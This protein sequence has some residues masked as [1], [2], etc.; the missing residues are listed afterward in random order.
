MADAQSISAA[1]AFVT[2]SGVRRFAELLDQREGISVEL[3]ARAAGVTSPDALLRLRDELGVDV[4]VVIG[5]HAA[6]FHP[7]LWLVRSRD[8]LSVMAGSGNL[9][10]GGLCENDEQ[11][12]LSRLQLDSD[13]AA[14]HEE[15]FDRLTANAVSLGVVEN[16]TIW[17]EWLTVIK[18]Q[19]MH[20][21]ELQRL[22][23]QLASRE[24]VASRDDDRRTL[25]NDLIEL[26]DL[27]VAAGLRTK[28]DRRYVPTRFKQAIERAE[29]GGDPVRLVYRI[30]RH[31]TGGFDVILSADRPKLTV[32]ALVVDETKP[33][34]DL[35]T[36]S[37]RQVAAERL[38]QF[39]S[40]GTA[41]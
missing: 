4:S 17:T 12:E 13:A 22:E 23:A 1:V 16:T 3:V 18:R 26:Y 8:R 14:E 37:T 31:Q 20:L 2:D 40:W 28:E 32:E 15:R 30:C 21:K 35:F 36:D 29:D 5:R 25:L 27:T 10:E 7:K 38:L 9:T 11:F 41:K 34:H 24:V 6:A 19:R 33:Y 39:P